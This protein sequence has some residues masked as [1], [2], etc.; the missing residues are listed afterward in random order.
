[1]LDD[2]L[3]CSAIGTPALVRERIDAFVARTR[4]DELMLT[5][6]IFDHAARVRSFALTADVMGTRTAEVMAARASAP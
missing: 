1:V 4:A 5:S 6:M 2:V 3:Q